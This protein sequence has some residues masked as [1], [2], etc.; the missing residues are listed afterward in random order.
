MLDDNSR[1]GV[2]GKVKVKVKQLVI[3]MF[4]EC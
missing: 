2:T 1:D 3:R 4:Y